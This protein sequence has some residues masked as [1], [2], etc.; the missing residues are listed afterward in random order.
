VDGPGWRWVFLI[1]VPLA[2]ACAPSP[3]DTSPSRRTAVNTAASTYWARR[4]APALA[5]VTYALIEARNGS[6]VVAL[7]AVAGVA[8][9]SPSSTSRSAAPTR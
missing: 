2:L 5:L 8:A 9:G 3:Y 4:W 7:T 6:L 1:N